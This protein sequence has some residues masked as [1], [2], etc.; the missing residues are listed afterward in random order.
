MTSR[1]QLSLQHFNQ[2]TAYVAA[3]SNAAPVA[4]PQ[5][6][7]G[8]HLDRH[9]LGKMSMLFGWDHTC[10][11]TPAVPREWL[12]ASGCGL[13]STSASGGVCVRHCSTLFMKHVLPRLRRPA[14]CSRQQDNE[15]AFHALF[16]CRCAARYRPWSGRRLFAVCFHK[17]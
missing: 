2:A 12:I 8:Q 9:A 16:S 11:A 17:S 14:P 13:S 1:V 5:R 7:Y 10:P 3:P 15:S 4:A 6:P